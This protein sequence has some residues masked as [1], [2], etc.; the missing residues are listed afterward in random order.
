[1]MKNTAIL[2][3]LRRVY[4]EQEELEE[5]VKMQERSIEMKQSIYSEEWHIGMSQ[6][7]LII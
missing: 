6:L 2:C 1:M 5:A 7:L 4:R 3:N